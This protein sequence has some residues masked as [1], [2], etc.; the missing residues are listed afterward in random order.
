MTGSANCIPPSLTG[1][2]GGQIVSPVKVVIDQT[3]NPTWTREVARQTRVILENNLKGI[4]H[5]TA[6]GETTWFDFA[7]EIFDYLKM[8]VYVSSCRSK[9]YGSAA[10]RPANSSLENG[11]LKK[12][13]LNV[14]RGYRAA[15]FEF[16]SQTD[17]LKL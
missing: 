15:L 12:A 16:L 6:E 17:E 8:P 5:A 9:E 2:L 1:C 10:A 4:I 11:V 3:G 14:M 7:K 13:G